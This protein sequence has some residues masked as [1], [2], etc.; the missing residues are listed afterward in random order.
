MSSTAKKLFEAA[1]RVRENAICDFTKVSV[2]CALLADDGEIYSAANVEHSL[3]GLS[4]CAERI[5]IGTMVS[6]GSRKIKEICVVSEFSPPW[7]PCAV[8]RQ[9]LFDFIDKD[10]PIHYANLNGEF[11]TTTIE[12]LYPANANLNP[13]LT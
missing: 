12:V 11:K 9:A 8:C 13:N 6:H 5:A 4:L 2:G 1:K 3:I 7:A 10:T